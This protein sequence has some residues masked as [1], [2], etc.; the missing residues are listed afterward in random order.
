MK[1]FDQYLKNRKEEIFLLLEKPSSL[2]S[3]DT[4]H[5]LRIEIKKLY[6]IFCLINYCSKD[7]ELNK[8]FKPFKLIFRQAGNVRK[9]QVEEAMINNYFKMSLLEEYK[10]RLKTLTLLEKKKY[11]SVVSTFDRKQFDEKFNKAETFLKKVHKKN[12]ERF[13]KHEQL[14]IDRILDQEKIPKRKLHDLRKKLKITNYT[15]NLL[16]R[17]K[18]K[19]NIEGVNVL[20]DLIGS[21]HDDQIAL[22]NL[23]KVMGR[24]ETKQ[25]EKSNIQK[26]R[27]KI[28]RN[29]NI[30][31]AK[32]KK[33]SAND[34][35]SFIISKRL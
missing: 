4:F 8:T 19:K 35:I 2:Y 33:H 31:Y 27:S 28:A 20:S 10:Q 22:K 29:G 9:L 30:L 34:A 32:I 14:K 3:P 25:T 23:K 7:F 17:F 26:I 5:K 16:D 6:A 15:K 11:F 24:H 13:L 18:K 21:W 1:W 12:V